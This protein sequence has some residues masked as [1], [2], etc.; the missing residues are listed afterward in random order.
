MQQEATACEFD[1]AVAIGEQSIVAQAHE[2]TRKDVQEKATQ[3]LIG[4]Q[5]HGLVLSMVGVVLVT[6]GHLT[7]LHGLQAG[8][9]DG[10]AM[11]VA[12]EITQHLL[13]AGEGVLGVNHPGLGMQAIEQDREAGR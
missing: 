5:G 13:G 3:E 10:D 7:V 4:L 6:K 9:A 1:L 2:A 12:A 11:G 8:V